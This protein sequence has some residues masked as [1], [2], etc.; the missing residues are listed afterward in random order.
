MKNVLFILL[1]IL[2]YISTS[3]QETNQILYLNNGSFTNTYNGPGIQGANLIGPGG[4]WA[5][6][7]AANNSINFDVNNGASPLTA[8]T[9]LQNSYVGIGTSSPFAKLHIKDGTYTGTLALGNDVYPGLIH[10][11][12]LSGEFRIDNRSSFI[13]YITFFPNGQGST[14]GTEAM[15][16]NQSGHVGIGTQIPGSKLHVQS[17]AN[18]SGAPHNAQLFI[19]GNTHPE[20]RLS[21]G[22]NTS[23]NYAEIQSQAYAGAFTPLTLNPNGGAV[24]IGTTN[25][26]SKLSVGDWFVEG[27]NSNRLT[28]DLIVSQNTYNS[29]VLVSHTVE[30]NLWASY[31][32]AYHINTLNTSGSLT[33]RFTIDPYGKVGIGTT[34]PNYKLEVNGDVALPYTGKL[35]STED[36]GNSITLHNGY[37]AMKF[38]TANQDRMVINYAGNVGVGT[39]TPGA[40]QEIYLANGGI[41]QF[42]LNTGFNGGNYI[43]INPYIAGVNNGGFSISQNGSIRLVIDNSGNG[44]VG[45]GT[46]TPGEKLTVNGK[47]LA[48]EIKVTPDGWSDYVFDP[49]YNLPDLKATE[50]YIKE[51]KHLPEVPTAS[52]VKANGIEL[53]EMNTLL[54]KKIEELTLHLIAQNKRLDEQDKK[55]AEQQK[56]IEQLKSKL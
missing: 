37:G 41:N 14:Q 53:G 17:D 10:S 43:D 27:G 4:F 12:A 26:V 23:S 29:Q 8:L 44:N 40:K 52:E 1:A 21:L 45:I 56:E 34:S 19:T 3:A 18:T 50:Q 35:L 47:V 25:P 11:S 2:L 24:G 38:N 6:R 55:N 13:G 30:H 49:S 7:N 16:I 48:R 9:I 54:L 20:K 22:Y 28:K 32:T 51:N 31:A 46:T 15:R 36:P 33:N 5:I 39:S 42:R